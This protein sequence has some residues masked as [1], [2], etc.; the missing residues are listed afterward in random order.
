MAKKTAARNN[1][2]QEPATE[3]KGMNT[4]RQK[5][6]TEVNITEYLIDSDI[7]IPAHIRRSTGSR[8]PLSKLAVGQSFKVLMSDEGVASLQ[9]L[10][11]RIRSAAY[12]FKKRSNQAAT[13]V[14]APN[15][16]QT[17]L[18]VWRGPDS[19]AR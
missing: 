3:E 10:R 5:E 1:T 6:H 17:G 7:P 8:F 13:F 18:R 19:Q 12:S 4:K 16:D 14:I 15:E 2:H 11:S 9:A